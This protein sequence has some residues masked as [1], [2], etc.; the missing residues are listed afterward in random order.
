MT[1]L[2]INCILIAASLVYWEIDTYFESYVKE[3]LSFDSDVRMAMCD[4]H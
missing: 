1:W 2:F 4:S 3:K